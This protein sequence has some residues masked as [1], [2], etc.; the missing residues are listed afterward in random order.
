MK[1]EE[2]GQNGQCISPRSTLPSVFPNG[3]GIDMMRLG[4]GGYGS[5]LGEGGDGRTRRTGDAGWLVLDRTK[6]EAKR[7]ISNFNSVA[8]KE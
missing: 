1:K 6:R 2:N 3:G 7:R 5:C 4:K 8:K